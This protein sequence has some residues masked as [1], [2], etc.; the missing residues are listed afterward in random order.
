MEMEG[1]SLWMLKTKNEFLVVIL[2]MLTTIVVATTVAMSW[3]ANQP[4]PLPSREDYDTS[5][6]ESYKPPIEELDPQTTSVTVSADQA[7]K[8]VEKA[9][10]VPSADVSTS[11]ISDVLSDRVLWLLEWKVD[12]TVVVLALVDAE[13]G[14]VVSLT[15]FR[16]SARVDNLK[17]TDKAV[18]IA[19]DLLGKLGIDAAQAPNPTVAIRRTPNIGPSQEIIYDVQWRQGYKGIPVMGGIASVDIDAETLNPIGFS[20]H[21]LD[22]DSVNINP[23]FSKDQAI[24]IARNFVESKGYKLGETVDTLLVIG[25]PN[26]YWEGTPMKLGDPTLIWNVLLKDDADR[27]I[28]V[29]VNAKTGSVI[30]GTLYR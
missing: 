16:R 24:G 18:N 27:R 15:D 22:V 7:V 5:P 11:L 20:I 14:E 28:D 25:R 9:W 26:Y 23:A 10:S 6:P 21:I 8:Q 30:G 3:S 13:K 1:F 12:G 19:V 2:V 4:D 17:D 29:W